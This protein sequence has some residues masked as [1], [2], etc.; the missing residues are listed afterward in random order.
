[1]RELITDR[2]VKEKDDFMLRLRLGAV[3]VAALL[4]LGATAF[5]LDVGDKAPPL[6]I[7]EW[8][9]GG[10][11]EFPKDIGKRLYLVEFWATWCPP[12]KA[13]VP[14]LNDLHQKYKDQ[15]S[16]VSITSAD[17][18]NTAGAVKRFVKDRGTGMSYIIGMDKG[19]ATSAAYL[20]ATGIPGIPYAYLVGK[21]GNLM[22]HGSPLD[23]GLPQIIEDALAGKYDPSMAKKA[24][25][26]S[27]EVNKRFLELEGPA[28][29]GQWSKVWD[30]LVGILKLDPM[31]MDAILVMTQVYNNEAGYEEKYRD[32]AR[33]H[34]EAHR[35]EVRVLQLVADMLSANDDLTRRLP[36]LVLEAARGAYEGSDKKD[37]TVIATYAHA[38]YQIGAIEKAIAMQQ[39][40]VSALGGEDAS[41]EARGVLAYYQKCKELQASIK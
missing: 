35:K 13:S 18:R 39:E 30:G 25:Q 14:L 16:V 40:A 28:Q 4:G 8:V 26:L 38:L 21:D 15:M 24:A 7:S 23:E 41:K 31:N 10:P 34:I 1:M 27:A 3:A 19:Q 37:A 17:E 29:S 5:G 2:E 36:D 33:G 9:Q 11:V 32:W 12:C 22:W 20:A 6:S